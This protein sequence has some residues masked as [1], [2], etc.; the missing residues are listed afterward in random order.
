MC[1]PLSWLVMGLGVGAGAMYLCD[2][3]RGAGRRSQLRGRATRAVHDLEDLVSKAGR[4]ARNRAQGLTHPHREHGS[5]LQPAAPAVRLVE[6]GAGLAL[7]AWGLQHRG[8]LGIAGGLAGLALIGRAGRGPGA[9]R[10]GAILV[11][12]TITVA[13]P[14]D[15]VFQ[16]WSRF[17]NFPRFMDHVLDVTTLGGG[18]SHWRVSG[19]AGVPLE[20]DAEVI[21]IVP[22]R[23]IGWR[24]LEG[25]AVEHE[26]VV[27]FDDAEGG[28]TRI[29]IRMGYRPPG[30]MLG[31]TAASF[32]AGDPRTLMNDDLLRF[33]SLL[34][35]GKT[36]AHGATVR[37]PLT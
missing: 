32:L 14:R 31:H 17:E 10:R 5:L 35:R 18:R 16:F 29:S 21:E 6:G 33:K 8:V 2:P 27:R 11:Q 4:D 25:S 7:A 22:Q 19:P 20:W 30:G 28:G 9:G 24:A 1:N 34:E 13:A 12:K 37:T 3:D 26:G 15:E 23:Q 36:T